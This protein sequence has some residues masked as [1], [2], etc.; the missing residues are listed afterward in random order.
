M[1]TLN[2]KKKS[3][4]NFTVSFEVKISIHEIS[5]KQKLFT[6]KKAP[7]GGLPYSREEGFTNKHF[8]IFALCSLVSYKK[9]VSV[10]TEKKS[11]LKRPYICECAKNTRLSAHSFKR[12]WVLI[13]PKSPLKPI[14]TV[15]HLAII[16]Q[17]YA[18][19]YF[20]TGAQLWATSFAHNSIK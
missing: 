7:G 5:S 12:Q 6:L 20:K 2:S 4:L 9:N 15:F 8:K 11:S 3:G 14:N 17:F 16:L 13:A 18:F 19:W 1:W 10:E